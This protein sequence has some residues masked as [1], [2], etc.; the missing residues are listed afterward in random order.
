[1]TLTFRFAR[2]GD[3]AAVHAL[4]ERTYRGETAARGWT[5]EADLL[6]GPRTS[7]SE[8][9]ALIAD[10]ASRFVLAE[11]DGR[12]AASAL[13]QSRGEVA[14]FGMFSVDPDAQGQGVG[15]AVLAAC[16]RAALDEWGAA[17][18]EM[19]VISLR[20]ELIAWYGRR[21]YRPTGERRPFPFGEHSGALRTDFDL[22][23][24]EKGLGNTA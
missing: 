10:P 16:E 20:Q 6:A 13:I 8:I 12:L 4:T 1:M 24:L 17:R 14:Y 9:D 11:D 3:A 7:R 15:R 21:G 23:V 5:H 2:P 22:V 18:L 19:T